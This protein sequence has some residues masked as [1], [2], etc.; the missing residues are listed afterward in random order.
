MLRG[1]VFCLL[2]TY[3]SPSHIYAHLP[4]SDTPPHTQT[5][6]QACGGVGGG[7]VGGW[8]RTSELVTLQEFRRTLMRSL[9]GEQLRLMR[10]NKY[11]KA[12]LA[13]WTRGGSRTEPADPGNG[14]NQREARSQK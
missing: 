9:K 2:L 12:T 10:V 14:N 13:A 11:P 4:L 1:D 6:T 3:T 8:A 5:Q 7:G